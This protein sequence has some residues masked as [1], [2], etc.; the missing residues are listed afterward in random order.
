M[1]VSRLGKTK[2][3]P[4]LLKESETDRLNRLHAKIMKYD[5]HVCYRPGWLLTL[6][7]FMSRAHVEQDPV[8]RKK[9]V[10]ELL[11]WRAKQEARAECEAE[12][13]QQAKVMKRI[14]ADDMIGEA[15]PICGRE[16]TTPTIT[17]REV[18]PRR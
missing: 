6:A 10:D 8:K 17:S 7:D 3:G 18:T 12:K 16:P 15:C 11:V 14:K 13:E 4:L 2:Y 1:V 5:I 9:M